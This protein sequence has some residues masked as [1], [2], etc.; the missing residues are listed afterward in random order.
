MCQLTGGCDAIMKRVNAYSEQLPWI[1]QNLEDQ[2]ISREFSSHHK[3]YLLDDRKIYILEKLFSK[4]K[5][6]VLNIHYIFFITQC[7][8]G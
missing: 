7:R 6:L 2:T 1:F 4:F 8:T 3:L 5:L